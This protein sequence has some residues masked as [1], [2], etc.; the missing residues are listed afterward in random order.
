M[1]NLFDLSNVPTIPRPVEG[2]D[3][4]S[5]VATQATKRRKR[6]ERIWPDAKIQTSEPSDNDLENIE[7]VWKPIVDSS[8]EFAIDTRAHHTLYHGARGP[9]KTITQLMRFRSRVGI[10]YGSYWRGVIFDRE[11]KNLSDLVTQSNRFFLQFDDG[12]IWHKAPTDYKWVWP[13]GE[14]LLFRHVKKLDDYTSYHGHEYSF[15]G[16][17]ELTKNPTSELYDK[18][19]SVN[20]SSFDP[21]QHTPKK[22]VLNGKQVYDTSDGLPLPPIPL[23]VFS[24]TNPNGPG[25]NWVKEKFIDAVNPKTG[26]RVKN[27]EILVKRFE[28]HDTVNKVDVVV[29]RKQVAIFGSFFENPYLDHEYRAGLMEACENDPHLEAAWIHGDWSISSGGVFDDLWDRDVHVVPQFKVPNGWVK[30]DRS[31]DWGSTHPFATIWWAEAN[32]EEITMSD[33]SIWCPQKGS[34][35]AICDDYGT[36]HIGTNKGL[37]ISADEICDRI[38]TEERIMCECGWIN[39]SVR[40]GPAD[41]QIRDV[42]Q[43]DVETIEQKMANRGIRWTKSDKSPGSRI[44]GAQLM[45]ERLRNSLRREGPGVYFTDNCLACI[46][47]LPT[48][49]RDEKKP[50]DVDTDAEDHIWDACR[51]RILV[52]NNEW[53]TS[54]R[55]RWGY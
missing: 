48:L 9:G 43:S 45:R 40:S 15:I 22:H 54:I 20:R 11:F 24:T 23:E 25:H 46:K 36:E 39:Q 12:A 8:Q 32:G 29:E 34:L 53:A 2:L 19:M 6:Q 5:I 31:F 10:G 3:I 38:Q 27:G 14:E 51:Y 52:G 42:T 30:L 28:F 13:T 4:N 50:D 21:E 47:I 44:I 26:K 55:T 1:T 17:N 18:F 7:V 16:W 37:K 49:P 41:N 35:I 33:G